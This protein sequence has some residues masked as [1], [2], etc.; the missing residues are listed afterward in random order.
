MTMAMA[1][2]PLS[3]RSI[4]DEPLPLSFLSSPNN[5]MD[6]TTCNLFLLQDYNSGNGDGN[7]NGNDNDNGVNVNGNVNNEEIKKWDF[8]YQ[9][10][11][12]QQV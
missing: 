10:Q 4:I 2:T 11:Q 6:I 12:E 9:S 8:Q 1:T 5:V 7:D 3:S